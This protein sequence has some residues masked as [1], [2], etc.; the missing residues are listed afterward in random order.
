MN[1]LKNRLDIS[2]QQNEEI[3]TQNKVLSRTK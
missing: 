3:L 1:N 2:T